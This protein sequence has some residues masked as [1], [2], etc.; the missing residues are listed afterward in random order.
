M[1]STRVKSTDTSSTL[2]SG[3]ML[4]I[5]LDGGTA[6]FSGSLCVTLYSRSSLASRKLVKGFLYEIRVLSFRLG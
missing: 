4:E 5:G 1:H 6:K 3:N 2:M